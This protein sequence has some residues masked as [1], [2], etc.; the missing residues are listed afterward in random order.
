[1][2]KTTLILTALASLTIASQAGELYRLG[3]TGAVITARKADLIKILALATTGQKGASFDLREKVGIDLPQGTVEVP[4]R[5]PKLFGT[6]VRTPGTFTTSNFLGTVT[7]VLDN[8][9]VKRKL[10]VLTQSP[11]SSSR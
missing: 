5:S 1:M 8:D 3:N 4:A 9:L 11:R 10:R 2:K 6:M 7:S